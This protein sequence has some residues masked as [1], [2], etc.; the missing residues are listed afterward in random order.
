M[1]KS[2]KAKN[3][4]QLVSEKMQAVVDGYNRAME[5]LGSLAQHLTL[6][7]IISK[8]LSYPTPRFYVSE[9]WCMKLLRYYKKNGCLP[10]KVRDMTAEQFYDILDR[11]KEVKREN[12]LMDDIDVM[13]IVVNSE[14]PRIYM[15]PDRAI[16]CYNNHRFG[17]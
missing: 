6:R 9:E 10:S 15:S 16:R 8:A 17:K 3:D 1:L 13:A 11:Y 12:V 2:M 14:A 4:E 5:E 7:F